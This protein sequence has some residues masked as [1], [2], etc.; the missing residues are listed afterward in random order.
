MYPI[1]AMR[2][3]GMAGEYK[4]LP[5]IHKYISSP[6]RYFQASVGDYNVA[7]MQSKELG[8]EVGQFIRRHPRLYHVAHHEALSMIERHRLMSTSRLLDLFEISGIRRIE[9]EAHCRR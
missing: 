8:M 6:S 2:D 3:L 9:V 4:I 7:S 5:Q 1:Q